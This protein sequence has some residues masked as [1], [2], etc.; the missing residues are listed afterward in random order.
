MVLD[1]APRATVVS[2]GAVIVGKAAGLIVIILETSCWGANLGQ[3]GFKLFNALPVPPTLLAGGR[4]AERLKF[5]PIEQPPVKSI[6]NRWYL[7]W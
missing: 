2:A 5:L 1:K 7:S 4:K 6:R 3:L